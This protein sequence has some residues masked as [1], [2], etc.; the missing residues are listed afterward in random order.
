ML[1]GF[2]LTNRDLGHRADVV[3]L[4][5][6]DKPSNQSSVQ[7]RDIEVERTATANNVRPDD[8]IWWKGRYCYVTP[9]KYADMTAAERAAIALRPGVHWDIRLRIVT[10][11]RARKLAKA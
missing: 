10:L 11:G 1:G 4:V 2:I 9:A 8:R 7:T 3:L 5:V 6:G